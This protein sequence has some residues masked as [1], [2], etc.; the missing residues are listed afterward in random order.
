MTAL[1]SRVPM[2]PPVM[3]VPS[4]YHM[5]SVPVAPSTERPPVLASFWTPGT[6]LSRP[7]KLRLRGRLM[8]TSLV[9]VWPLTVLLTS[10]SG[11]CPM[12]VTCSS[13]AAWSRVTFRLTVV[14]IWTMM[15]W[16]MRVLNPCREKMTS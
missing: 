8:N 7:S 6:V 10:I 15:F 3:S 9:M 12:T 4:M 14:A 2:W 13:M 16:R 1:W 5:F 11:L